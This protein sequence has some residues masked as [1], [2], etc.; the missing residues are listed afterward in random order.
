[1]FKFF[2]FFFVFLPYYYYLS[3]FFVAHY[4]DFSIIN[5]QCMFYCAGVAHYV[6]VYNSILSNAAFLRN[7]YQQENCVSEIRI[8]VITNTLALVWSGY[9]WPPRI[10][11]VIEQPQNADFVL[12]ANFPTSAYMCYKWQSRFCNQ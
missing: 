4:N 11:S 5:R 9:I 3:F 1:M 7:L 8:S 2:F 6:I 12:G 10:T